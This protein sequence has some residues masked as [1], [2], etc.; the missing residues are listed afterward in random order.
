[1]S[2]AKEP[3]DLES[4]HPSHHSEEESQSIPAPLVGDIVWAKVVG[5]AWY[6][7]FITFIAHTL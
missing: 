3:S 4:A 7:L 6:E 1:M 2:V 5:Y